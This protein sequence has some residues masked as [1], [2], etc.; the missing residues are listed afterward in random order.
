MSSRAKYAVELAT[1]LDQ[2]RVVVARSPSGPPVDAGAERRELDRGDRAALLDDPQLADRASPSGSTCQFSSGGRQRSASAT[3]AAGRRSATAASA[4]PVGGDGRVVA[5]AGEGV[6]DAEVGRQ[7]DVGVA[8]RPQR[9]V[10]GG[11]R[12][13]AGQREQRARVRRRGRRRGRAR[14][15]PSA[16]AAHSADQGAAARPRHRQLARGR[17]RRGPRRRGTGGSGRVDRPQPAGAPCSATSRAATVRAP[18]T[19]TCWPSTARTAISWPSTWP[20]TRRPGVR[21]T[22]GPITG[23]PANASATAT[24]SQSA[25]SSR[26]T[27]STAARGVAQ[28]VERERGR[29]ER[30][31]PRP[32]G[33]RRAR[34]GR[35]RCRAAGESVRAYQPVTGDL[36]ARDRAGGEEAE[37]RRSGVRRADGQ[38]HRRPRRSWPG[39]PP[40]RPRSSVGVVA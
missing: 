19:L 25:S 23:S 1:A 39:Q 20:G 27:R 12:P 37:Q 40:R 36:D 13:D 22:S 31:L 17:A 21:R 9:D 11:P 16:S 32:V 14:R 35:C 7:E 6:A 28:V 24:G 30:G 33:V 3:G 15:S 2:H 29:H 8:E 18:A 4:R 34:G 38:A 10:V 26:R 5:E